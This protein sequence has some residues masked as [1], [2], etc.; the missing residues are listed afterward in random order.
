MKNFRWMVFFMCLL[1]MTAPVSAAS[2][3]GTDIQQTGASGDTVD[4]SW[5]RQE[6]AVFY[7]IYYKFA[8]ERSYHYLK[9]MKASRV[10]CTASLKLPKSGRIYCIQIVPYDKNGKK[11]QAASLADCRTV[12]GK[13]TL[14][15]QKSYATSE[16]MKVYWNTSESASGYEL[17]VTDLY[18]NAV[19]RCRTEGKAGAATL[20]ELPA[21]AFYRVRIR[22]YSRVG[23]K[24]FYGAASYT[25]IAQQPRVKFKWASHCVVRAY[26]PETLGAVN[27]TVYMTD[28][29]SRGFKKAT[30]VSKREAYIPGLSRNRK[31]YA[32]VVANMRRGKKT[33][34][35]PRTHYYTFRLQ[36]DGF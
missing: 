36:M 26:W 18:G 9:D 33:Y 32:Y 11:G 22:G 13:I 23:K 20:T 5:K 28:N 1:F 10:N 15:G 17:L 19:K 27:Y 21:G 14:R 12:P 30:T 25:Y 6:R 2:L 24:N 35:S 29:P 16:S 8:A 4:L 31:Y 7:K 34:V 3:G